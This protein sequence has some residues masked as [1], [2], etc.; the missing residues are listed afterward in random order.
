MKTYSGFGLLLGILIMISAGIQVVFSQY[1]EYEFEEN[2]V[3]LNGTIKDKI[4]NEGKTY[5]SIDAPM[6]AA[7]GVPISET[8]KESDDYILIVDV[9]K[10]KYEVT[11]SSDTYNIKK[12][13]QIVKLKK[14]KD[15]IRLVD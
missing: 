3:V 13:G 5:M 15:E 11:T 12:V 1:S 4:V 10:E 14:Y 2:A 9:E 8:Q 7:T 6:F